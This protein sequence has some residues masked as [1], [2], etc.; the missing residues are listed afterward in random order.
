MVVRAE[1]RDI[2]LAAAEEVPE[3]LAYEVAVQLMER[4]SLVVLAVLVFQIQ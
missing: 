4:I 3:E 2:G 1:S